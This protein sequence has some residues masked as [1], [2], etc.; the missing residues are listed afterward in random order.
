MSFWIYML[1]CADQSYYVGHT[2]NLE[3]RVAAHQLGNTAGYTQQRRP[4]TLV[5]SE[6]FGTRAEALEQERRIKRWSRAK[7]EALIE[8][9]WERISAL[10]RKRWKAKPVRPE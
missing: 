4:V 9:D 6:Y 5:Y 8:G 3:V 2:D 7:K 1:R 10:A